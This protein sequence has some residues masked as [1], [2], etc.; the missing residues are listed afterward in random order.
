MQ[1]KLRSMRSLSL[2]VAPVLLVS[3]SGCSVE[4]VAQ[5]AADAAAC[6]ALTSTL[7]GLSQA[8][9]AGL[10][11]SGVIAQIDLLVGEQARALLSSGLADDLT[12]LGSTLSETQSAQDAEQQISALTA[13]I[14]ERCASVGVTIGE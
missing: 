5:T 14:S 10:V 11:D 13:S 3:L 1:I 6:T 9:Q 8:Y 2:L 12:L 4:E 7:D